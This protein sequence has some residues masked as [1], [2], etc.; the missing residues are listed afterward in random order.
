VPPEPDQKTREEIKKV[1][2]KL[3]RGELGIDDAAAALDAKRK[4]R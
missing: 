4:G 1:L 2:D 3:A